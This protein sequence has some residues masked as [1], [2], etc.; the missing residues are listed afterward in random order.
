MSTLAAEHLDSIN[1]IEKAIGVLDPK[2]D[3]VEDP[4]EATHVRCGCCPK[5]NRRSGFA[6]LA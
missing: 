3:V 2:H 5:R 6:R 1:A 4:P